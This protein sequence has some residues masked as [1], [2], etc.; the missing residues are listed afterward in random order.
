MNS[1]IF[2]S[3]PF[4]RTSVCVA[5]TS[6][7]VSLAAC[8]GPNVGNGSDAQGGASAQRQ[9]HVLND[10]GLRPGNT[11]YDTS[12][13]TGFD[14]GYQP[15]AFMSAD[16]AVQ[17]DD[18][19]GLSGVAPGGVRPGNSGIQSGNIHAGS[20]GTQ[21]GNV[22]AGVPGA[23][24]QGSTVVS[25]GGSPAFPPGFMPGN[26]YDGSPFG[27]HGQTGGAGQNGQAGQV[28]P[29]GPSGQS[30]QSV[31]HVP[32][33]QAAQGGNAQLGVSGM[34][35][36]GLAG[37]SG[38]AAE[39]G[40][41]AQNGQP[42]QSGTS[43]PV[44]GDVLTK[45]APVGSMV[46]HETGGMDGNGMA[47]VAGNGTAGF[48]GN[49]TGGMGNTAGQGRPGGFPAE[50]A[51]GAAGQGASG[52]AEGTGVPAGPVLETGTGAT[53][54][55]PAAGAISVDPA[56]DTAV[57]GSGGSAGNSSA[58]EAG[59]IPSSPFRFDLSP[60][61]QE[62]QRQ[63]DAES[64]QRLLTPE[65]NAAHLTFVYG[66]SLGRWFDRARANL[67][68]MDEDDREVLKFEP[69]YRA[70]M[71]TLLN[72]GVLSLDSMVRT[73]RSTPAYLVA[74]GA[75]L[76]DATFQRL[77]ARCREAS[78]SVAGF[79]RCVTGTYTGHMST[80]PKLA[81]S[82]T[83]TPDGH[84][85]FQVGEQ[86][87]PPFRI[88][89]RAA[90]VD[91]T[92]PRGLRQLDLRMTT[93]WRDRDMFAEAN[94][95][96][97]DDGLMAG[98]DAGRLGFIAGPA[99]SIGRGAGVA[100]GAG[101]GMGAGATTAGAGTGT[102]ANIGAA[103]RKDAWLDDAWQRQW[104]NLLASSGGYNAVSIALGNTEPSLGPVFSGVCRIEE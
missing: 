6:T 63:L 84:V 68:R 97:D 37:Q 20:Y 32:S 21:G 45:P 102:A 14:A 52:A 74:A 88:D 75:R 25:Q 33:G 103:T 98:D 96:D 89:Y 3:R 65:E 18:G 19:T 40:R 38:Q 62:R 7:F 90:G 26:G 51:A 31:Q 41:T 29:F 35:G 44:A 91:Y 71:A 67:G 17:A 57:S 46:Q 81:C 34:Q 47:G 30:G 2:L 54:T 5:L 66:T 11:G 59:T 13:Y 78:A 56:T 36:S 94:G 8:G 92:S 76:P 49:G 4:R 99:S 22:Q 101:A 60:A 61:G 23:T 104:V 39:N 85:S 9:G 72:G 28:A 10:S 15:G 86:A 12:G 83:F 27:T 82:V 58:D 53:G 42:A 43:R 48:A 50:G 16:S 95:D 93:G 70:S 64:E 55:N 1:S 24:G 100:A 73:Y 77:N 79:S 87:Y 80:K 69:L